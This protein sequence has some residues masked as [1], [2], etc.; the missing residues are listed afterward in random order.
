MSGSFIAFTALSILLWMIWTLLINVPILILYYVFIKRA[1]LYCKV[2]REL[3]KV[4]Q[5]RDVALGRCAK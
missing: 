3:K 2:K 4:Q 1:R 5:E